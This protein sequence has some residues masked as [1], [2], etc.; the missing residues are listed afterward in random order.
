MNPPILKRALEDRLFSKV[1]PNKVLILTGARRVG[2][3]ILLKQLLDRIA[4]PYLFLN[5][6]DIATE[7]LLQRRSIVNYKSIIGNYKMLVIDEAQKISNI[8]E[9]LK[10]MVDEIP[11]LKIIISGSSS[12]DLVNKAG[13]PLTGRKYTYVLHPLAE[14]E[15]SAIYNPI[16]HKETL[17]DRLIYGNY[18][19]LLSLP[20]SA[21]KMDYLREMVNSYLLKDLLELE[22]VR[23]SNKMLQLLKLVAFQIGS[24]LSYQE[25]GTQLGMSKNTVERYLDLFSKVFIIHRLDGFSRNLRKEISKSPK[26]Y[27]YDNGIR[28]AIIANFNTPEARNDMGQL[29]ENYIL[30][31]R[32]KL[33]QYSG[34]VVN[35][36]FWRTYDRQE[37]DLIEERGGELFAYEF[38]LTKARAKVPP[39][40]KE[41]YAPVNFEVINADNYLD[42]CAKKSSS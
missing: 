7:E 5:G 29:W 2:K 21:E 26:W 14:A 25:L 30:A 16:E 41:G 34:M 38:K 20:G 32:L 31:E 42:F 27:F 6:E 28:N 24:T 1:Q 18:P 12:F 11:D 22:N 39:Q 10:L 36:Y 4:E 15:L 40:W 19:E 37:I 17:R 9:K 23:N 13:E 8:G 35:N 33:Q 3:T